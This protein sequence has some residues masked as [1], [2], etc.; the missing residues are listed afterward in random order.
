M[1]SYKLTAGLIALAFGVGL[2]AVR[3]APVAAQGQGRV[4]EFRTYVVPDKTG[5]DNLVN[6]M[7]DT[8]KIFDRIGMKSVLYA[9][10]AEPPQSENTFVYIL[11]HESLEKVKENWSRFNADPE[12][13]KL[14]ETAPSP[15]KLQITTLYVNPTDFSP[16]MPPQGKGRMLE[17]RTYTTPDRTGLDNLVI[18]MRTGEAKI[19]DKVGM[20]PLLFTVAAEPPASDNTYMYVL[21]H[22]NREKAKES[23]AKFS[24]DPD[25]K[26]LRSTAAP[27]GQV[28]VQSIFV[29]PTAFSPIQ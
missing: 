12:R 17:I 5:L 4:L 10:A 8:S 19:F 14:F 25:W 6:R 16:A 27:T 3:D 13:A 26:E 23:W 7:A 29:N 9:V 2:V 18:R 1:R 24:A 22:E 20:K 15:G 11:A 28:K 21:A